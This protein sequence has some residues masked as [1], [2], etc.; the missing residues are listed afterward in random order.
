MYSQLQQNLNLSS[1]KAQPHPI[2]IKL[3]LRFYI[4]KHQRFGDFTNLQKFSLPTDLSPLLFLKTQHCFEIPPQAFTEYFDVCLLNIRP[5]NL[6]G[7]FSPTKTAKTRGSKS[8]LFSKMQ[9]YL[10]SSKLLFFF[11]SGSSTLKFKYIKNTPKL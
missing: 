10:P 4:I 9:K 7:V 11:L 1:T 2:E 6:K 3:N 8:T 5:Q